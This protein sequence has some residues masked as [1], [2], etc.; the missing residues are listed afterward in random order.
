MYL[1]LSLKPAIMKTFVECFFRV[2][3]KSIVSIV[4]LLT[5]ILLAQ[6]L[7]AQPTRQVQP[8]QPLTRQANFQTRPDLKANQHIIQDTMSRVPVQ[9]VRG[10]R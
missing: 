10:D 8:V 9:V 4:L 6:D 3:P 7:P 5:A 1:T 2:I